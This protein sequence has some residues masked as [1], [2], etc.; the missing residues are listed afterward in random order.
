LETEFLQVFNL[1]NNNNDNTTICKV[2]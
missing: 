2:P 1:N